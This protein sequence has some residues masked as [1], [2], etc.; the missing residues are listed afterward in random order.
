MLQSFAFSVDVALRL[1]ILVAMSTTMMWCE[2]KGKF[3]LLDGVPELQEWQELQG[4][5]PYS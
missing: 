1:L 5:D 2:T 4:L 3:A